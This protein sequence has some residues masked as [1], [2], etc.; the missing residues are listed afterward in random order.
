MGILAASDGTMSFFWDRLTRQIELINKSL[1]ERLK[2][3]GYPSDAPQ[4][5]RILEIL[6]ETEYKKIPF[7]LSMIFT[8]PPALKMSAC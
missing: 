6:T 3:L 2:G 4:K 7:W 5:A 8:W 1:G